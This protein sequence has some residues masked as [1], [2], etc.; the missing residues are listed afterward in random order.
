VVLVVRS[1]RPL[2]E[3]RPGRTLLRATGLCVVATVLLPFTPLAP[4]LG[5]EPPPA[6]ILILIGGIVALYVTAAEF[7]KR[8]F[9]RLERR[10]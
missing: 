9:Y 2:G 7:A 3:S 8:L 4:L 6:K 5:L 1:R 10:S